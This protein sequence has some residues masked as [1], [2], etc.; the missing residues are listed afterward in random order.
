MEHRLFIKKPLMK[1]S[2]ICILQNL[3]CY[4]PG[5]CL[6]KTVWV[7]IAVFERH[8]ETEDAVIATS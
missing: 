4:F 5:N 7:E 3:I 8:V 1:G 2:H 6:G